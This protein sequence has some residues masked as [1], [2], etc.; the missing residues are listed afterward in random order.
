MHKPFSTKRRFH[1]SF[2]DEI[3]LAGVARLFWERRL[4]SSNAHNK[5]SGKKSYIRS[6]QDEGGFRYSMKI[7]KLALNCYY[8]SRGEREYVNNFI[9]E[10]T[11]H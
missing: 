8:A 5:R 2:P 7:V 10:Q 3:S 4:E 6:K 1:F 11:Q 9:L